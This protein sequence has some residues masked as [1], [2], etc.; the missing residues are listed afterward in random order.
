M[1][2]WDGYGPVSATN[3][4]PQ[5]QTLLRDQAVHE[6]LPTVTAYIALVQS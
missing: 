5:C 3:C 6:V 2:Q 4:I 1:F